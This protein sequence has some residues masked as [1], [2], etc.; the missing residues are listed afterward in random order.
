LGA[1]GLGAEATVA[2]GAKLQWL[3]VEKLSE[4]RAFAITLCIDNLHE[5]E[6]DEIRRRESWSF[7]SRPVVYYTGS[8]VPGGTS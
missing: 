1:S 6:R 2:V 8:D 5:Q 7:G 3:L 4:E